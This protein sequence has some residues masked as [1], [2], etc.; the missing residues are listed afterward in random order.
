MITG[1]DK[2]N[3]LLIAKAIADIINRR[4]E[5]VTITVLGVHKKGE[6]EKTEKNDG[7]K[8]AG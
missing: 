6:E 8:E 5:G 7:E 2:P 4:N 3:P 1:N